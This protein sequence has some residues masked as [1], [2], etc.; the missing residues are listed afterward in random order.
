MVLRR[1]R[2]IRGF[3]TS[4]AFDGVGA[5]GGIL[6]AHGSQSSGSTRPNTY[7]DTKTD[8]H[9]REREREKERGTG[10]APARACVCA[11]AKASR[12][13]EARVEVKQR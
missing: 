11:K 7:K 3:V 13:E 8:T 6:L 1:S 12:G 4:L 2:A 5:C 10:E 9:K